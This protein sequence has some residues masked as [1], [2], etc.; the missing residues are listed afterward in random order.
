VTPGF[1][2]VVLGGGS[3]GAVVA[4]MISADPARSVLVVEAGPCYDEATLPD[5]LRWLGRD[6]EAVHDWADEACRHD[7]RRLAYPHGRVAGGSSAVNGAAALWPLPGDV[8]RWDATAGGGGWSW[9]EV[10]DR[11]TRVED[12]R[13]AL[14]GLHGRGGPIPI[15]RYPRAEWAPEQVAFVETCAALG[16]AYVEDLNDGTETAGVGPTPMNRDGLRRVSTADAFLYPALGRPNLTVWPQCLADRVLVSRGR[17]TGVEVIRGGIRTAVAAGD[18][19]V[20]AGAVDSPGVLWRSGIGPAEELRRDGVPVVC[21]LPGVGANLSDHVVVPLS[22]RLRAG[23]DPGGVS[24]IAG[25]TRLRC[26][27]GMGPP[28]DLQLIPS[29]AVLPGTP[30]GTSPLTVFVALQAGTS[31]GAVR[32]SRDVT[33]RPVVS[34]TLLT[35]QEDVDALV[36]GMAVAR[37]LLATAPLGRL[38]EPVSAPGIDA[39]ALVREGHRAFFHSAGTCRLGPAADPGAVVDADLRVHGIEGLSVADA[40]A[41]PVVPRSNPNL[42][43]ITVGVAAADRLCERAPGAQQAGRT[44][45]KSSQT[46]EGTVQR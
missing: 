37:E 25:P 38:L 19:V 4:G 44:I 26:S 27:S 41:L 10:R 24:W 18:V 31:R 16:L 39:R 22:V 30:P 23:A 36:A 11:L 43:V 9:P 5:S 15:V 7:G 12:D 46:H 35:E 21:D 8:E 3:A 13:D 2:V 17:V 29:R 42:S 33:R 40:S 20:A 28:L 34:W 14:D 1:D 6:I 32:P 45:E